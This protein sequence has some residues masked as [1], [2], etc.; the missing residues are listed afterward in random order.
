MDKHGIEVGIGR[1]GNN[2][3]QDEAR[4]N[5][6]IRSML[7]EFNESLMSDG[8]RFAFIAERTARWLV[9]KN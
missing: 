9:K 8:A 3:I 1:G 2:D 5:H 6:G 7:L 4:D